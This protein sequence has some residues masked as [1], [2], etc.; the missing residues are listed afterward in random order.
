MFFPF[1][2][3]LRILFVFVLTLGSLH[4]AADDVLITV[5]AIQLSKTDTDTFLSSLSHSEISKAMV[6]ELVKRSAP[7]A[8]VTVRAKSGQRLKADRNKFK[9]ELD[10]YVKE[11]DAEVSIAIEEGQDTGKTNPKI[12]TALNIKLGTTQL[13]GVSDSPGDGTSHLYLLTVQ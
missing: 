2:C 8:S 1:P 6:S 4:A 9:V 5:S 12:A 11:G 3:F 7:V 10:I 13:V